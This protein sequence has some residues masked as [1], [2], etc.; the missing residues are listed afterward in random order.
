MNL[1]P[2]DTSYGMKIREYETPFGTLYLKMHPLLSIHPVFKSWGLGL[3]V[4]K[5]RF[6]YIDDTDFRPNIQLPDSDAQKDEFLTEAGLELQHQK[7]HMLVKN[8]T[9]FVA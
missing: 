2:G 6:S 4:S 7:S 9:T 1:V 3:D 8:V 5:L